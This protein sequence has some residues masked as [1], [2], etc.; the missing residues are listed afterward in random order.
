MRTPISLITGPLGSGKTT[1]LRHILAAVPKKIAIL[2]NEFGE[3][4]VDSRVV[5]GRKRNPSS[6]IKRPW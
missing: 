5:S 6:G 4:A 2:M 1:L 3:L